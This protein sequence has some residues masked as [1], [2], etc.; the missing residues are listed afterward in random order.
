MLELNC[1]FGLESFQPT[2]ILW[3]IWWRLFGV[4]TLFDLIAV[5]KVI[6]SQ[7]FNP[8]ISMLYAPQTPLL[9]CESCLTFPPPSDSAEKLCCYPSTDANLIFLPQFKQVFWIW[10]QSCQGHTLCPV[11]AGSHRVPPAS[12]YSSCLMSS[13][14]FHHLFYLCWCPTLL[15]ARQFCCFSY[16]WYWS[17]SLQNVCLPLVASSTHVAYVMPDW[18][19]TGGQRKNWL[20]TL[21]S[22]GPAFLPWQPFP[23]RIIQLL[24]PPTF[25]S[26]R[27]CRKEQWLSYAHNLRFFVAATISRLQSGTVTL[28][29]DFFVEKGLGRVLFNSNRIPF[30][31]SPGTACWW[32]TAALLY[33]E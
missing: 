18:Q 20:I 22:Y 28:T 8:S 23:G 7:S 21:L 14:S 9:L 33:G 17:P 13:C 3:V 5:S 16:S 30:L 26:S 11:T 32:F 19:V 24:S 27:C 1:I 31:N 2:S 12:Y 15:V 25:I 10:A 29:H 4:R 6:L